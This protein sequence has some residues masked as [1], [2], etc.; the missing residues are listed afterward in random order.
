MKLTGHGE[1]QR[2]SGYKEYRQE[3][4]PDDINTATHCHESEDEIPHGSSRIDVRL[5]YVSVLVNSGKVSHSN[6]RVNKRD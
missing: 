4:S 2:A 1:H 5:V 6:A 3:R